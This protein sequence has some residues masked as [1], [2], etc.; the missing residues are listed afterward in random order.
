MVFLEP[1]KSSLSSSNQPMSNQ[2]PSQCVHK[3]STQLLSSE[4]IHM[5]LKDR[6]LVPLTGL[7]AKIQSWRRLW[8]AKQDT[9]QDFVIIGVVCHVW[10]KEIPEN[11]GQPSSSLST[12]SSSSAS[13]SSAPLPQNKETASASAKNHLVV[14][15]LSDLECTSVSLVIEPRLQASLSLKFGDV[16]AVL[17]PGILNSVEG[18]GS[19]LRVREAAQVGV[20]GKS[21]EI[22]LCAFKRVVRSG[23][24]ASKKSNAGLP[25]LK[26]AKHALSELKEE[27]ESRKEG[28]LKEAVC[29]NFVK[30]GSSDYCEYHMFEM[31]NDTKNKRLVLSDANG[32]ALSK[33]QKREEFSSSARHV[34]D[35]VYELLGRKWRI[36]ER[37]VKVVALKEQGELP[38]AKQM[39]VMLLEDN[40]ASPVTSKLMIKIDRVINMKFTCVNGCDG[41]GLFQ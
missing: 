32:G 9:S 5:C 29:P 25:S 36:T 23:E 34:S 12:S 7:A 8:R 38:T 39:C 27:A 31:F 4:T 10:A 3:F 19:L 24:G 14:A 22:G 13:L 40:Q 1:A 37:N 20:L 18:D 21:S 17:N 2:L 28:D 16:V 6:E 30:V 26:P 35:G 15:R 41:W 33:K 11:G